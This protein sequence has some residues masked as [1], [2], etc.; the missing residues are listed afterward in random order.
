[1][2]TRSIAF[3][4]AW[5]AAFTVGRPALAELRVVA[6]TSRLA[7]LTQAVGGSA[8][9]VETLTLPTQ[10][11]HWVDARPHLALKLARADLLVAVGM[12]LEVGWLPTLQQAARNRHIQTG[13]EGYL[14][15]SSLIAPLE[16]PQGAIDRSMGDVHPG[17]SP[18]YLLDPR[19]AGRVAQG[20]AER[21]A[22]LDPSGSATY[23]ANATQFRQRLNAAMERWTEQLRPLEQAR[24]VAY[25]KSFAYLSDWVGFTVVEHLEPRPGIPPNPRHVA[26]VLAVARQQ[27]ATLVLQEEYFPSRTAALIADRAEAR[28]ARLP[29]GP[30]EGEGY[31]DHIQHIVQLI[32]NGR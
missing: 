3:L 23:R 1:M 15:C 31:I 24:V 9:H 8:V 12:E 32:T 22:D 25:H 30:G 26:R 14:D 27:G 5:V 11:P 7:A 29:G 20:I 21:L 6:T 28:L 2:M 13:G 19:R 18:H 17:G 10:D 4:L 16:V